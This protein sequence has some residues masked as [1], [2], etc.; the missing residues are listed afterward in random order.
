MAGTS[1]AGLATEAEFQEAVVEYARLRKWRAYHT[2]DSRRSAPGFPDLVLVRDGR[3][4]F[5][6]LKA[7]KG[8]LSAAQH[9][10]MTALGLVELVNEHVETFVFRPSD[11]VQIEQVL[12]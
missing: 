2:Y 7:E 6:E 10:W 8:Q 4:V 1:L 5:V 11:W 12:R 9:A 3:L